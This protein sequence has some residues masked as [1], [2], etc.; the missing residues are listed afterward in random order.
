MVKVL[1]SLGRG[2][3]VDLARKYGDPVTIPTPLGP[4]VTTI[5]P[6]GNKAI[7]S[8]DPDTFVPTV[9][10]ALG[11]VL[12]DSVLFQEG[13]AHRRARKLLAPPFHGA[14][15]RSYGNLMREATWRYTERWQPGQPFSAVD[16]TQ[17]ITI[18]VILSAVFGVSGSEQLT[19]FRQDV[20]NWVGGFSPFIFVKALRRDFLG[21]GPWARFVRNHTRLRE[22]VLWLIAE[23]RSSLPGREDILSML[24][25]VRDEQGEGLA[26]DEI[27]DQLVTTVL[28]GHETTAVMLAWALYALHRNPEALSRLRAELATLPGGAQADPEEIARRPFLEAV[29]NETLRLYPPA[30]VIHR[31]LKR[32]LAVLGW[33]LPAGT[34]VGAGVYATHRLAS[35]YPD[36]E[37]F[38]PERFLMRTFSPF[39]F[40]PWGGGARRCLGAPFALYEMKIVLATILQRHR[41]RLLE[42]GEVKLVHRAGT[43]GPKGGIRMALMT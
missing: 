8:A 25:S 31:R 30:H 37:S 21:F 33:Q 42:A 12:K 19:S 10:G 5:S 2:T 7:F 35:L 27:I 34:I 28:A 18:D 22:R 11:P 36:P 23:H 38:R 17:A 43:V 26:D 9:R 29:C 14:R 32:P 41:L 40:L 13:S 15:M 6:E 1:L 3:L 16:T 4:M 39:E 24:L 20:V